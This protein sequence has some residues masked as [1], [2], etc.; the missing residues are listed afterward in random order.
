MQV[1]F[2]K[3]RCI[4]RIIQQAGI[5]NIKV[6]RQLENLFWLFPQSLQE[7]S[8]RVSGGCKKLAKMK[9]SD[10]CSDEL[11]LYKCAGFLHDIGKLF[12]KSTLLSTP[13]RLTPGEYSLVQQHAFIGHVVVSSLGASPAVTEAL[14]HHH[15]NFDGSGYPNGLFG[16]QIPV[17]ARIIHIIDVYDA[18]TTDRPYRPAYS[19]TKA[20]EIMCIEW[21]KFD[22]ALIGAFVEQFSNNVQRGVY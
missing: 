18:L 4:R 8:W 22:P 9:F 10:L 20:L 3:N 13:T 1:L 19:Q 15:E 17:M 6:V 7:H 16:D 21:T 5:K 14:L 11:D 2:Q 12:I